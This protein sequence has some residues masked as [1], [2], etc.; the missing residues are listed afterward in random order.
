[1]PPRGKTNGTPALSVFVEALALVTRRPRR[2]LI[3][4]CNALAMSENVK[5]V[6]TSYG[7]KRDT[8][9]LAGADRKPG[10]DRSFSRS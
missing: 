6:A 4:R 9:A 7:G 2:F 8:S 5:F 3:S 10:G 1:M